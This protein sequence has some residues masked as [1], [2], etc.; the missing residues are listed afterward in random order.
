MA[1]ISLLVQVHKKSDRNLWLYFTVFYLKL[2][3]ANRDIRAP[4][5][6][7]NNTKFSSVAPSS[8]EF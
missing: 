4:Q 1:L 3:S 5:G 8:E 6:E 7:Q 2:I